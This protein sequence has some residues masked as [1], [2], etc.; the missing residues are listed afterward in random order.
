M[1]FRRS[2][3]RTGV[4][5]FDGGST[6]LRCCPV[7][8]DTPNSSLTGIQSS[9][10]QSLLVRGDDDGRPGTSVVS[11][12]ATGSVHPGVWFPHHC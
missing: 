3:P 4:K 6:M 5:N 8:Q 11:N 12:V 7:G 2:G 9:T 1:I 10:T